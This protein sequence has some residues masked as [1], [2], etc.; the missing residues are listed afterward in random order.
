MKMKIATAIMS[1]TILMSNSAHADGWNVDVFAGKQQSDRLKWNGVDFNTD[2]G[3]SYGVGVS[4]QVT[5]RVG[6]G[7]EVGYTKNQYSN[8]R[9]NSISGRSLML[10]AEYDFVQRRRFSFYGGLGLGVIKAKYSNASYQNSDSVTGGRVSLGMR[11][12]VS[13]RTK[14][15]LE[16]R[17]IDTFKDPKIALSN[18]SAGAEY[19]GDSLLLGLRYSF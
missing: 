1:A 15:F 8:F 19:K 3:K 14:L 2:S 18:S 9:P 13:P 6:L 10:T 12:A 11:Y 4:K 7:F 5:P 17:H 16:A